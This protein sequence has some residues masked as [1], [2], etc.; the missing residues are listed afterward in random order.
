MTADN[1]VS[2]AVQVIKG[3]FAQDA[4]E[5]FDIRLQVWQRGFSEHAIRDERD[6]FEHQ[7][8]IWQNPVK[9]GKVVAAEEFLY[10]SASGKYSLDRNP[11]SAAAKAA[12][13]F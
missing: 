7:K 3:R 5:R 2:K 6:Y 4:R 1:S 8:Y 10:S 11:F 9:A 13:S 12:Q